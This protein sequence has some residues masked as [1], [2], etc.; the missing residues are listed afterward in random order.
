M[1][2]RKDQIRDAENATCDWIWSTEFAQ[3]LANDKELIFWISGKPGSGK[4]TLVK[5]LSQASRKKDAKSQTNSPRNIVDFYFDFRQGQGTGNTESG[6]W[7]SLLSQVVV[8]IPKW[9]KILK[10]RCAD[11]RPLSINEMLQLMHTALSATSQGF[12]AFVDGLD[13]YEGDI[14][15]LLGR[16]KSLK[17]H[18]KLKLCLASRPEP[19]IQAML[20]SVP[21]ISM[22]DYNSIGIQQYVKAMVTEFQP[23][24][25]HVQ[26]PEIQSIILERAQGVFLWV[27]LALANII[28]ACIHGATPDEIKQRLN[29][30]PTEVEEL[31]ERIIDRIPP[32][33]RSEAAILYTLVSTSDPQPFVSAQLLQQTSDFL[34]V[35]IGSD[36]LPSQI[37]DVEHFQRRFHATMGGLLELVP[38]DFQTDS[39]SDVPIKCMAVRLMHET[40]RSFSVKSGWVA[41]YLPTEFQYALPNYVWARLCFKFL[42]A[43][44][45]RI[46]EAKSGTFNLGREGVDLPDNPDS[47]KQDEDVLTRQVEA[48][49][50]LVFETPTETVLSSNID[51][52]C[53]PYETLQRWPWLLCHSIRQ[54]YYYVQS[55]GAVPD[56]HLRLQ[57]QLA[58]QSDLAPIHF[59]LVGKHSK[60][61]V[62]SKEPPA[63]QVRDLNLAASHSCLQYLETRIERL[64]KLSDKQRNELVVALVSAGIRQTCKYVQKGKWSELRSLVDVILVENRHIDSF[65]LRIYVRLGY[66]E[67]PQFLLKQLMKDTRRLWRMLYDPTRPQTQDRPPLFVWACDYIETGESEGDGKPESQLQVLLV[68]GVDIN[69]RDSDR[70]N[71]VHY[72]ITKHIINHTYLQEDNMLQCYPDDD[73]VNALEKLYLVHRAGADFKIQIEHRTPLQALRYGLDRIR[74]VPPDDR[75][76]EDIQ[77]ARFAHLE[78]VLEHEEQTGHL[79]TPLMGKAWRTKP[80]EALQHRCDQCESTTNTKNIESDV[81]D[82]PSKLISPR[83]PPKPPRPPN[84][85]VLSSYAD[86]Q[87][88]ITRPPRGRHLS[89]SLTPSRS[90]NTL[91]PYDNETGHAISVDPSTNHSTSRSLQ[92]STSPRYLEP[93]AKSRRGSHNLTLDKARAVS[94]TSLSL[95]PA[96]RPSRSPK[97][98]SLPHYLKPTASSK[99][100]QL[101]TQEEVQS[102]QKST[103]SGSR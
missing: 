58:L 22:S 66:K 40:V 50:S 76:Y 10:E 92:P 74:E 90:S 101:A 4:S 99:Q 31:Y 72:L 30:L 44:D 12:L 80:K 26:L 27:Y 9:D 45:A 60:D 73:I 8:H 102:R 68:L 61:L 62:L 29:S 91:T 51:Q 39:D 78:Y 28:T 25:N 71:I 63:M 86:V 97:P 36:I 81:I 65:H 64:I 47:F 6:L 75:N 7:R 15:L 88:D 89:R 32:E 33:R 52:Q 11:A 54:L 2:A 103:P 85:I 83:R 87:Q 100:R 14:N 16:L 70:Y 96:P 35:E 46:K 13:E 69:G 93:T 24:L 21:Q 49:M 1:N 17:S 95:S 79:P 59:R 34:A 43:V 41:R 56:N 82:E 37:K 23:H 84:E 55:Y 42:L 38:Q 98:S 48:G 57:M 94:N 5:F 53:Y 20:G 67:M 3:W 19:M 18:T 77:E